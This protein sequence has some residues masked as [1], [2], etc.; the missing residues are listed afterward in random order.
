M[1]GEDHD[2]FAPGAW[3]GGSA[4]NDDQDGFE[5]PRRR[6]HGHSQGCFS[7]GEEPA[8]PVRLAEAGTSREE[9][10]DQAAGLDAR[11]RRAPQIREIGRRVHEAILG[12]NRSRMLRRFFLSAAAALLLS[13]CAPQTPRAAAPILPAVLEETGGTRRFGNSFLRERE[14]IL[15]A[16]F[17]GRPYERGYARGRLAYRQ[18]AAGERDL[19]R[20]LAELVPSP[21]RRWALRSLLALSIRR[22]TKWIDAPHREEIRGVADAEFPD[23]VPGGWSPYARQLSLHALHD[24]SQRFIDTIPLSGACSGFAADGSRSADGH[25]YLARNFDFE[26]GARFDREKI[27]AAIVPEE[28]W[29]FLT[30]TFGGMTGAVSGFNEKG[31]GVSLQSLTGGPT[32]GAGQPSILLVA[33]LLQHDSTVDQAVER[34][35]AARVFV[36][37]IYLLADAAGA[38]AVVEKTPRE[39][40]VRRAA[41]ILSATNVALTPEVSVRT[42]PPPA[43][44]SSLARQA[45]LDELLARAR[46]GA[47][48]SVAILRDREGAG[49]KPLGP[50]NRNAIDALIACHAVVFDLSAR[51]AWV[52]AAPHTLGKFVCF[53][54]DL[55]SFA[56]PEDPRFAALA[57][58]GVPADPYLTGGGYR[59]YLDARRAVRQAHEELR[60]GDF[61]AARRDASAALAL[62]PDFPEA[63]ASRAEAAL[64]TRD[65]AGAIADFDAALRLDPGPPEFTARIRAFRDAAAART[66][67]RRFL[68]FPLSLE[69]SIDENPSR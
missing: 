49:S 34:I 68:T 8:P 59:R 42:G 38:L 58:D 29:R 67:P 39:T 11:K 10:R 7:G 47:A 3:N 60:A 15:E 55:L 2:A 66:I 65:F 19:D 46:P 56:P 1:R 20:L 63:F 28:G 50:G 48:S 27:V 61:E 13:R 37:D 23:P 17:E 64:R 62:A 14:G 12:Q 6:T 51:R 57:S 52:A 35:R 32:S 16:R 69:D 18:I 31:L 33:D 25:V 4:R 26:A 45:R 36:S 24:F 22:S 43:S 44:S 53:D 21:L 9:I 41:G 40:G 30:V 5:K 54:L